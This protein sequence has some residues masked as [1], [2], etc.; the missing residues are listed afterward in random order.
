VVSRTRVTELIRTFAVDEVVDALDG[1][2]QLIDY[3]DDRGHNW[4]HL[5]SSIDVRKKSQLDPQDSIRLAG[6]LLD[7]GIDVNEPAF[8][9]GT[10]Q[11]TA[12]WYAVG[13]GHNLPLAAFLLERG[14]TPEHCL[15]AASFNEDGEMLR[16]LIDH[17]ADLEAVAEGETPLLG[18]VKMSRF[19]KVELLL[20]AGAD[21]DFMDANG[22]T[23]LHYMLKKS[24]DRQYFEPFAARGARGDIPGPD[25]RTAIE[26]MRRKRDPAYHALADR[27]RTAD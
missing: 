27:L 8:T 5:A 11:A 21:P 3:R 17:G 7:L 9:E 4:L 10:W 13:R 6:R 2:P 22:M 1:A 14:S 24:S 18:A 15:W 12:L 23:A 19:G 25:G 16:L 26:I 20:E